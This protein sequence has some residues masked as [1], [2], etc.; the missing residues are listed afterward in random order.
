MLSEDTHG[1]DS[2][3]RCRGPSHETLTIFLL[4]WDLDLH[5]YRGDM[6]GLSNLPRV[7]EMGF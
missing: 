7:I 2:A 5:F 4:R 6:E 1:P 3:L